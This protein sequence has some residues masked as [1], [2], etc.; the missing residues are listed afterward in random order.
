MMKINSSKS[1]L[2]EPYDQVCQVVK[3]EIDELKKQGSCS[4]QVTNKID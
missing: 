4:F 2:F 1:N 3:K